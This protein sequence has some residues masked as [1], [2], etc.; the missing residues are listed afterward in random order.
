MYC[1][2][3]AKPDMIILYN[4]PVARMPSR[5]L[6]NT[7]GGGPEPHKVTVEQH[8]VDGMG[9]ERWAP[10]P[11]PHLLPWVVLAAVLR[12][13]ALGK[14]TP[15]RDAEGATTAPVTI[16]AREIVIAGPTLPVR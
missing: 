6:Y 13:V 10:P 1:P 8:G 9:Q 12:Q 5:L 15:S 16:D 4:C 2:I 11:T 3:M 7:D 14:I